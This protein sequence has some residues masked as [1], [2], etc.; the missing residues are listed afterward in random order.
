MKMEPQLE[1]EEVDVMLTM[2][3]FRVVEYEKQL[4]GL[5]HGDEIIFNATFL[6]VGGNRGSDSPRHLHIT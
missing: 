5:H 4:D 3:S 2:D 6:S 1:E